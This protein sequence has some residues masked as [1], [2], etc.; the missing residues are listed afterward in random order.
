M[1]MVDGRAVPLTAP[2]LMNLIGGRVALFAR[3]QNGKDAAA[4]LTREAAELVLAALH[5]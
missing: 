1:L 4:D 5:C 3:G 2:R